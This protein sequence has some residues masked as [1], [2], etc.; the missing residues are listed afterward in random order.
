MDG[1]L[2]HPIS[3]L[4]I[5]FLSTYMWIIVINALISWVRPDPRNPIVKFLHSV[6][7]PV[8]RPIR[9]RIGIIS[10]IDISPLIL[11]LVIMLFIVYLKTGSLLLALAQTLNTLLSIYMWIMIIS[12]LISWIKP[13]P[14]NPIVRFLHAATDPVLRPIR[15]HIGVISGI[16]IS[17][18]IVILAI[19]FIKSYII[20]SLIKA[21]FTIKG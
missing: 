14:F 3:Q 10:G 2:M 13:D 11:I 12:A 1:N 16:D 20:T 6:T 17:P 7:E 8:L 21:A 5:I 15:K 18:I 4:L 19:L 9:Q